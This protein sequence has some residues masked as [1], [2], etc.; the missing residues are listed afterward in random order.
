MRMRRVMIRADKEKIGYFHC[1][2]HCPQTELNHDHLL[3]CID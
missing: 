1:I 2:V 3:Q